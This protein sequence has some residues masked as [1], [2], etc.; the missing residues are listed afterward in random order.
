[1]RQNPFETPL[2]VLVKASFQK[3]LLISIPHLLALAITFLIIPFS[4]IMSLILMLFI[5]ASFIFYFKWHIYKSLKRSL[6]EV[7]QDSA[8]NWLIRTKAGDFKKASLLDSSFASNWL[9]IVNYIDMDKVRYSAV[10]T[11]D[12]L[13]VEDFRR[14]IVRFKLT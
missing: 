1:M 9:I 5:F 7:R 4:I 10:F 13:S 3:Q 11:P 6:H 8:K 2:S 12:S 14:L